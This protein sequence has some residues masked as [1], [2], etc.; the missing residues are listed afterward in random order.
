MPAKKQAADGP[1]MKSGRQTKKTT[2]KKQAGSPQKG[3]IPSASDH[4]RASS[5]PKPEWHKRVLISA[6]L[7]YVNN[8]PHLGNIVPTISAD[9]YARF[10]RLME[11]EVI[12]V[13]GTD[14]HGTTTE[15]KALEEGLTPRQVCDKYFET[16][17][18]IYEFFQ[19]KF[20]CFGRTSSKENRAITLDIFSRLEEN[21]YILEQSM[22]QA[23]CG[24]CKR[25]LADRFVGG[26]CP[27]CGYPEARGDQC[28]NCGR[29]LDPAELKEP[30][31]RVCKI[32]KPEICKTEHL[33]I[34]LPSLEK[35]LR[36][37]IETVK[38]RWTTN[39][40]TMTEAWLKEGLRPRCI[41]R[42]LQW[43][44]PVP[45]KGYDGK[46]FYSWFDA[47]IG[48][49]GITAETRKDWRS[50]WQNPR[51]VRLV[52][53]MG[54]DNI[55]FH[56]ILFPAFL[57]GTNEPW[58][59]VSD[60]SVNEF[61]NLEGGLQFS[62][63]RGVG[64]FGDNAMESGIPADVWRYY[65]LVN[66]P[67]KSDTEF[68][69]KDLQSKINDELVGNFGNLVNRTLTFLHRY[70]EDVVDKIKLEEADEKFIHEIESHEENVKIL[71]Q[72]IRLKD[73]LKEIMHISKLANQYFQQAE[74]WKS[75]KESPI[76]ASTTIGILVNVVK[77]LSIM[78]HPFMPGACA[79]IRHQLNLCED[80]LCWKHLGLKDL[81]EGHRINGPEILFSKID[82]VG[83][84]TLAE[85]F[86]F[87]KKEFP[88]DFRVAK[89]IEAKP[90]PDAD[91][92]YILQ[93]DVGEI[94]KRQIVAGIRKHY[95]AEE[96]AGKHIVIVAN[97]QPAKLRGVESQGM[98]L[99]GCEKDDRK[100]R[101]VLAPKSAP[102]EAA[103]FSGLSA[104]SSQ[105]LYD[106][107]SKIPLEV[108]KGQVVQEH[109]GI[110]L[111]TSKEPV[112]CDVEDHSKVR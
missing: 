97:L 16:H 22:D 88:A 31:C 27:A 80:H 50:W 79:R 64:V 62:K 3:H 91:K 57:I 8:I 47:P 82:D 33:F 11:E 60:L 12:F 28:E 105:I 90:H 53:F 68:A 92:L 72:E 99:A 38:P 23:F 2:K 75:I 52:Q 65:I 58:T 61:L 7:P 73:A 74:P 36:D 110:P 94:G 109:G 87:A 1:D 6:A 96:L 18:G 17:K 19:C 67:E 70:Y 89:I 59:L 15:T 20:D 5:A 44:I 25:F 78:M 41:T 9:A 93:V 107:F 102:G 13:C 24:H 42:D 26:T 54:K 10:L 43:G 35:P 69:W 21:G 55:P 83:I 39:A 34:D 77:D 66:R 32:T 45:K 71:M 81:P 108:M 30:I 46:V 101:L 37:W 95:S 51:E 86:G 63:S 112:S 76:R 4:P 106:E 85:R 100:V 14:E 40:V 29:L 49:I 98:L 111:C 103:T 48:Y 56:T 104:K 84:L